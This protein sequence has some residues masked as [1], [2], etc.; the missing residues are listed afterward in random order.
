M[1]LKHQRKADIDAT[2]GGFELPTNSKMANIGTFR[3]ARLDVSFV[4]EC[5]QSK[6]LN[7]HYDYG[8]MKYF[9]KG[10]TVVSTNSPKVLAFASPFGRLC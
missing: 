8:K 1:Q 2:R 6:E 7:T 5:F 10:K 9:A 4:E 3:A